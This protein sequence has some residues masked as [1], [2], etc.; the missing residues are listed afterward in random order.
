[1]ILKVAHN[2]AGNGTFWQ[3]LITHFHLF[4]HPGTG[5][6]PFITLPTLGIYR[7]KPTFSHI[8]EKLR[9]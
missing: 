4:S 9:N 7:G 1:M 3:V 6:F 2:P 5:I 8:L